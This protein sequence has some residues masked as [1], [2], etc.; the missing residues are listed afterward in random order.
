MHIRILKTIAMVI[1]R[2]FLVKH[3]EYQSTLKSKKLINQIDFEILLFFS[4]PC[5]YYDILSKLKESEKN[6]PVYDVKINC[7]HKKY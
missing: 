5:K 7:Q 4:G 3:N 6:L 1:Y 2:R